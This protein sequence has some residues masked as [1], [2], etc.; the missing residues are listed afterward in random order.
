[1]RDRPETLGPL[2]GSPVGLML[3]VASHN[4]GHVARLQSKVSCRL[5]IRDKLDDTKFSSECIAKLHIISRLSSIT[6]ITIIVI[7]IVVVVSKHLYD[8]IIIHYLNIVCSH[9][10]KIR[11]LLKLEAE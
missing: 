1:M 7:I 9:V 10:A 11:T 5:N 8:R 2:K 3:L 6:N 4:G